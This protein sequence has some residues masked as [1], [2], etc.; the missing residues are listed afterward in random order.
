VGKGMN[1]YPLIGGSIAVVVLL[2]LGSLTNV[3]GYQSI[4]ST[5]SSESPLFTVRT[6]RAINQELNMP[7]S[8]YL[9]KGIKNLLIFNVGENKGQIISTI[10]E[11]IKKMDDKTYQ[12]F[13]AIITQRLREI[14]S[15]Q[16]N[17]I[18]SIN[19]GLTEIRK[20]A[21][22]PILLSPS[23][24]HTYNCPTGSQTCPHT[25]LDCFIIFFFLSI[26]ISI[27]LIILLV[28]KTIFHLFNYKMV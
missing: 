27:L 24:L 4:S 22:M 10:I 17:R 19:E 5:A 28:I 6:K 25:T 7:P 26:A 2:V 20:R 9:G 11:S 14:I 8:Q 13:L 3:V 15:L 21:S 18:Q 1:K 23:E 16:E 12:K